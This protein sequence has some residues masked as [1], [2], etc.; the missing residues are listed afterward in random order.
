MPHLE[1][2]VVEVS[3]GQPALDEAAGVDAGRGVALEVDLVARTATVLAAEEVVEPDLV[4]GGRAGVG[5][6]VAADRL[7][8]DVGPNHHHGGVPTDVGAD[9]ALEVLVAREV[10]LLVGGDGV[11][12]GRGH[13]GRK[14]DVGVARPLQQPEQEIAGT[15]LAVDGHDVV[16]RVQPFPSLGRVD[17]G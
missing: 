17:I 13:R 7:G 1:T 3:F 6:E 4:E 12:V 10:G 8:L 2:E 9:A 14:P 15:G 16:E 11:H 5:G